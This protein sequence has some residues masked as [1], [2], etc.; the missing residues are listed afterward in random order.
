[1]F[2]MQRITATIALATFLGTS[3]PGPALAGNARFQYTTDR[4][5]TQ[6]AYDGAEE[7]DT[8]TYTADRR[9]EQEEVAP[10]QKSDASGAL[11]ALGALAVLAMMAGSFSGSDEAPTVDDSRADWKRQKRE[12]EAWE[13]EQARQAHE[14]AEASRMWSNCI[15]GCAW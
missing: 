6:Q 4:Y 1:M 8:D 7:E 12:H 15:T 9:D 14:S 5:K 13:R 3:I 10:E 2:S 11:L